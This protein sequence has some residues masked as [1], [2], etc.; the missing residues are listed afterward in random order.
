MAN[1]SLGDVS[2]SAVYSVRRAAITFAA[3]LTNKSDGFFVADSAQF[4]GRTV[5]IVI[6]LVF[7]SFVIFDRRKRGERR[8]LVCV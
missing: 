7:A 6:N 5:R 2:L 8:S 4:S 3:L 1:V